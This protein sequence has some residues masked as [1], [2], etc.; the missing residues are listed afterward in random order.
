LEHQPDFIGYL[1]ADLSTP[2]SEF[3]R[4]AD[5]AIQ[6]NADVV[7]GSRIKTANTDIKRAYCDIILV[8]S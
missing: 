6:K 8:V 5:L 1:D 4:L 7:F 3:K 2:L